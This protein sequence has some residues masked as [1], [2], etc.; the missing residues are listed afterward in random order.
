MGLCSSQPVIE[1]EAAP[2]CPAGPSNWVPADAITSEN[3]HRQLLQG[4]R[5]TSKHGY[6]PTGSAWPRDVVRSWTYQRG[7]VA[8]TIVR[9]ACSAAAGLSPAALPVF[10]LICA[11]F[12][13]VTRLQWLSRAGG[14]RGPYTVKPAANTRGC[15]LAEIS[16]PRRAAARPARRAPLLPQVHEA[17]Q[18]GAMLGSQPPLAGPN[19]GPRG[20]SVDS[21]SIH[22][23]LLEGE[24]SASKHGYTSTGSARSSGPRL[25]LRVRS[26]SILIAWG[27]RRHSP[28]PA[29]ATAG[30]P[31]TRCLCLACFVCVGWPRA[32]GGC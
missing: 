7:C 16:N 24:R 27:R 28:G 3:I 25:V 18:Q 30:L 17:Q 31:A 20:P 10:G 23:Q 6:T 8:A 32:C 5:S 21:E 9:P 11:I 12:G 1:A 13:P 29:G 22:R 19:P 2:A 15:D 26:R 14:G 4:E